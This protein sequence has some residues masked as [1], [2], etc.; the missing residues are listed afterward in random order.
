M[1]KPGFNICL[2][3]DSVLLKEHIN[4]LLAAY[5]PDPA[6]DAG[7]PG[8]LLGDGQKDG[9]AGASNW[10]TCVFWG[11]EPLG[12]TFWE[13]LTLQGLFAQ[14]RVVILR[15]A[16]NVNADGLKRISNALASI[17]GQIWPFLCFEVDFEYGKA[18]IPAHIS[19]LQCVQFAQKQ[20]WYREVPPLSPRDVRGF[21]QAEAQ[22]QNLSFS[23][24]DLDTLARSMQ[25]DAGTIRLEL[26][27]IAL[28]CPD[29]RLTPEALSMLNYQ[30]DMD[31]FAFLQGLQSGRNPGAI[32]AQYQKDHASAA[33]SGLFSFSAML[34]REARIM[35]QILA[36]EPTSKMPP[37]ALSAKTVLARKLGYTGVSKIWDLA[38]AA[39][40]GV[41][42]GERSP[43]QAFE[44]L[45]AE[46]FRLFGA[47]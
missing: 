13:K 45:I 26:Q 36:G 27:K 30:A 35:W 4:S 19:K 20:G 15:N 40:K 8:S 3:P 34:L 23:P 46:L 5:K 17:S 32:W 41:K 16:Q 31:I 42:S 47:V 12:E 38:L 7:G 43:Q 1:S 6:A 37:Q 24:Q 22:R 11:D 25:P 2:G 21:V 33:D 10:E 44:R 28:A 9:Q 18:K 39:D 14:P 29:G